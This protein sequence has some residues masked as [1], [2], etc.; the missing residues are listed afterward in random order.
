MTTT[1]TRPRRCASA[2]PAAATRVASAASRSI[3][4]P[5]AETCAL[6]SAMFRRAQS[7][8][9][10]DS[11]TAIT[12]LPGSSLAID[13]ASAADPEQRSTT[14]RPVSAAVPG[15]PAGGRRVT[16]TTAGSRAAPGATGPSRERQDVVDHQFRLRTRDEHAG[17]DVQLEVAERGQTGQVLQRDPPGSPGHERGVRRGLLVGDVAPGHPQQGARPP[18][19]V[20][21]QQLGVHLRRGNT[22]RGQ[23]RGG[24]RQQIPGRLHRSTL[25]RRAPS[26]LLPDPRTQVA[27]DR[28]ADLCA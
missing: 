6:W 27:P 19:D 15:S 21:Q 24:C 25:R 4:L 8:A 22:R 20:G 26:D 12:R 9:A 18:G 23:L 28:A 17:A 2:S 10:A 1:S 5:T 11:S 13:R 7:T 3:E 16:G 14:S